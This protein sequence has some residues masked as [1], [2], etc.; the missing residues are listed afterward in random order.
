MVCI[1]PF[2][3]LVFQN[4]LFNI[5]EL[6]NTEPLRVSS[7]LVTHSFLH[8]ETSLCIQCGIYYC[9][10]TITT[11]DLYLYFIQ[12]LYIYCVSPTQFF[13]YLADCCTFIFHFLYILLIDLAKFSKHFPH[14]FRLKSGADQRPVCPHSLFIT[15]KRN[16]FFLISKDEFDILLT[17]LQ[18]I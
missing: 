3:C 13:I 7:I 18:L 14:L 1:L 4:T 12:V 11:S 16:N 17:N 5:H 2:F 8:V 9:T 6:I 10:L 15:Y